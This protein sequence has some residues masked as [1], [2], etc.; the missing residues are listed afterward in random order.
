MLDQ[1]L[2]DSYGNL[3]NWECR[4]ATLPC[5]WDSVAP[6]VAEDI[7]PRIEV[8]AGDIVNTVVSTVEAEHTF[9]EEQ[10]YLYYGTEDYH[11]R[12]RN[13]RLDYSVVHNWR[14]W[15]LLVLLEHQA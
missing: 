9:F 3:G 12:H 11:T 8:F 14:K 5:I 15:E 4:E 1:H 10:V 7:E 2:P 13:L 6:L